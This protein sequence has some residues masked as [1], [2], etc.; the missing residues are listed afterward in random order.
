MPDVPT[1]LLVLEGQLDPRAVDELATATDVY[2]LLDDLG[3]PKV[4]RSAPSQDLSLAVPVGWVCA[5]Q[6][7]RSWLRWCVVG[8]FVGVVGF[9]V[10]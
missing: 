1:I 8:G 3:D 5:W 10:G 6:T 7:V 9:V 2:G 4:P